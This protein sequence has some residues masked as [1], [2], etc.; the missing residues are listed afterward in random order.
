MIHASDNI[1][2]LKQNLPDDVFAGTL[3]RRPQL[4]RSKQRR[5]QRHRPAVLTD[6]LEQ[7]R[8]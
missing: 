8:S 7:F 6:S 3:V 4:P 1:A 5:G 2:V